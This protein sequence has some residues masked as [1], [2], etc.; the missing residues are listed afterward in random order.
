MKVKELIQILSRFTKE[1]QE[2]EILIDSYGFPKHIFTV[3]YVGKNY[4]ITFD[5]LGT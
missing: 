5:N 2:K 4:I 3:E 1:H